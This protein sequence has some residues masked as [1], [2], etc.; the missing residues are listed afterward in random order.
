MCFNKFLGVQ[1]KLHSPKKGCWI[2]YPWNLWMCSYLESAVI[3]LRS[4]WSKVSLIHGLMFSQE[5]G[6]LN[7]GTQKCPHYA[8]SKAE[9]DVLTAR[10]APRTAGSPQKLK[11]SPL[12]PPKRSMAQMIPSSQTSGLQNY[13]T[14]HFCCF[15]PLRL[16]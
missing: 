13:E 15:K 6:N 8:R 12:G 14:I 10:G 11:D 5:E 1:V 9:S 3:T 16:W 2:P 7:T 4:Y